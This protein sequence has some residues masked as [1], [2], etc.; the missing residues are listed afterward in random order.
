MKSDPRIWNLYLILDTK[1][2]EAVVAEKLENNLEKKHHYAFTKI[3]NDKIFHHKNFFLNPQCP[4][5]HDMR[6]YSCV[7]NI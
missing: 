1:Y 4:T 2:Q 6:P 5:S 7:P 3:R